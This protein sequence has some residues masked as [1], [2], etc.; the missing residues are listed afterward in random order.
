[1][2]SFLSPPLNIWVL[3]A[4]MPYG[5]VYKCRPPAPAVQICFASKELFRNIVHCIQ[6]YRMKS[7]CMNDVGLFTL[8]L[9][10]AFSGKV[11]LPLL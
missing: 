3:V 2:T 7:I 10:L 8:L 9:V 11:A 4:H 5:A 1:M 6:N